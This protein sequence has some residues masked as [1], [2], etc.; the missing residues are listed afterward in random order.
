MPQP[1]SEPES[2]TPEL[3]SAA[4]GPTLSRARVQLA[5]L[6]LALGGF[7]IGVTEFAAMGLLRSIADG[8]GISEPQAGTVISAYA[9]GVVV[10]A[11]LLT[12]WTSRWR[13]RTLLMVLMVLFTVGNVSAAFAPTLETLVAA[14][15]L[16]GIPHGAYFGVASLVAASLAGAGAQA[17]AVAQ[18]LLGLSVANVIGVPVATWLGEAAGWQSAFLAVGVIGAATVIAILVVV[19]EPTGGVV[20]R[21]REE[22]A[23]LAR[24]QILATLAVGAVGFGGMFAIYTYIQWTM[25][26]V[27][28]IDR[29][30]M[31]AV[32][33]V[34]GL[35]MVAGN[36]VGGIIADRDLDRGLVLIASIMTVILALFAVAAQNPVTAVIGLFLVGATGS[37][38]VPGL[39][40]RLMRYAGRGQ[41]LAASL[42][43]S[44]LNAANALGAWLGGLVIALGFG[45]TSPALAGAALAA[46]GLAILVAAVLAARRGDP[47]SPETR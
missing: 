26:D 5:I 34:Y 37:A 20:V 2:D 31:P 36:V 6:A 42:N 45:Y 18:V 43:H 47:P 7:G 46:I 11:P 39:Q 24:P 28:G 22:L 13:R 32:L 23:A 27:A 30:W 17:R 8:F 38:L 9:L 25:V 15:F 16:A 4:V 1:R 41:T 44:A 19:P 29:A 35:G 12:V 10:G 3:D 21:A 14:R 40:T 33:A